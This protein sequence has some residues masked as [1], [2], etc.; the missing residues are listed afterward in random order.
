M[1]RAVIAGASGLVGG[2]LL[3]E[4]L[5]SPDYGDV[6]AVGRR[7]L[8]VEHAKLTK[9]VADFSDLRAVADRLRGD[10][11]FCCLGTTIRKAGTPEKF[12]EVDHRAVLAFAWVARQGGARRFLLISALGA[13]AGARLFYQRVKG[14]TEAAVQVMGFPTTWIF[15]PSLLLGPR[16]EFRM[17]ERVSGVIMRAIGPLL[18]RSWRRYRAVEAERVARAMRRCAQETGDGHGVRIVESDEI[19]RLGA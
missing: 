19:A 1:K 4:L 11:A 15:R 12:C 10:D 8:G 14:E 2:Y 7:P 3:R 5:S 9:V 13:D 17:G 16:T 18:P 6:V